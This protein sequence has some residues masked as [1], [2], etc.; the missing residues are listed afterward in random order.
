MSTNATEIKEL[1]VE[2]QGIVLKITL[3]RPRA[4][5]ALTRVMLKDFKK[6]LREVGEDKTVRVVVITGSGIGFCAG[7]DLGR[8]KAETE[9]GH[10][11]DFR[12]DLEDNFH[13]IVK[14]I[15]ALP[16]I[17]VTR[18]NGACAGAGLAIAL[19]GD[20]KYALRS[21][22]FVAAFVKVGLVPDTG[23]SYFFAKALGYSRALE[24]FLS[25]G[26]MSAEEL[27]PCGLVNQVF[28]SPESLD[29]GIEAFVNQIAQLPPQAVTLTKRVLQEA[30]Q[31]K[32]F[33]EALNA[34]AAAQV[35]LGATADHAEGVSAFLEK[36]KPVFKGV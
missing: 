12:K 26:R 30:A 17:V 19:A 4:F 34:E 20:V 5:N 36:R 16:Q 3:N 18:I 31:A 22:K 9:A 29:Q 32:Y 13:P 15:R 27:V 8:F 6:A 2:K 24:F 23:S 28:D 21:A 35:F 11:M 7:A 1:V 10:P 25:K 14:M 33:D